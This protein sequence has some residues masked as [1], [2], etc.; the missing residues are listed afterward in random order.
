MPCHLCKIVLYSKE[1]MCT[2]TT[3]LLYIICFHVLKMSLLTWNISSWFHHLSQTIMNVWHI[4][5]RT[6]LV[7]EEELC[8]RSVSLKYSL[9][10]YFRS[11]RPGW[12]NSDHM[13]E[14]KWHFA[15]S[16]FFSLFSLLTLENTWFQ[17]MW[18]VRY[19]VDYVC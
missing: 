5:F 4:T 7:F 19:I 10:M 15:T 17:V 2:S 3:C 18:Y 14:W 6:L 1:N 13:N 12:G 9:I 16:V 8:N 11:W